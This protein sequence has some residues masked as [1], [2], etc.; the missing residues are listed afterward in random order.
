MKCL[1][2]LKS[3]NKMGNGMTGHDDMMGDHKGMPQ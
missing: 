3:E 1:L 2:V